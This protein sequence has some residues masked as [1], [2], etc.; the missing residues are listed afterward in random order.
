M[1]NGRTRGDAACPSPC[2]KAILTSLASYYVKDIPLHRPLGKVLIGAG[3]LFALGSCGS[4]TLHPA[5]G[6]AGGG[7]DGGQ[8][9]GGAAGIAGSHGGAGEAGARGQA[10]SSVAGAGGSTGGGMLGGAGGV[11]GSGSS[12]SG[13]AAGG[14]AGAEDPAFLEPAVRARLS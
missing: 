14:G 5:D 13:G 1:A 4:A 2:S 6:G 3:F 11:A 10:G 9:S 7:H 8:S 12:G